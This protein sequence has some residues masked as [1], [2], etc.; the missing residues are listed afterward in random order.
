MQDNGV[1]GVVVLNCPTAVASPTDA[2]QAVVEVR[3]Q[4][5]AP[6]C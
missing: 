3:R 1:D 2:A 6:P 4:A 5:Q